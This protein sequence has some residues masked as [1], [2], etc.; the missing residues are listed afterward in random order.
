MYLLFAAGTQAKAWAGISFLCCSCHFGSALDL[1]PGWLLQRVNGDFLEAA[2]MPSNPPIKT[3]YPQNPPAAAHFEKG[4][5]ACTG[6][7]MLPGS[8]TASLPHPKP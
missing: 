4:L 2:S 7:H 1:K 8:P 6:I 5:L 3:T